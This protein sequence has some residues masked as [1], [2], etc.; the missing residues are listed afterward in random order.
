MYESETAFRDELEAI[1]RMSKNE[2]VTRVNI[3]VPRCAAKLTKTDWEII[4][5]IQTNP[6]LSYS[7]I[8]KEVGVSARTAKRRLEKMI[9]ELA[10]FALPSIDPK[11]P[12]WGDDS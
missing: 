5:T 3:P 6:R 2:N 7:L 9:E 4:K 12:D 11:A 10:L 8:S 1:A